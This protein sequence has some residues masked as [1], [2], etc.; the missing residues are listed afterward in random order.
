MQTRY[1]LAIFAGALG[2]LHVDA[3]AAA[4]EDRARTFELSSTIVQEENIDFGQ[5]GPT[6]GDAYAYS[7]NLTSPDGK[8]VGT[9]GAF[10]TDVRID[11]AARTITVNCN[12]TADLGDGQIAAQGLATITFGELAGTFTIPITGGS[13]AYS[14]V[15]GQLTV[16]K[17]DARHSRMIFQIARG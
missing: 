8:P 1:L 5:P 4:R 2:G 15:G 12:L 9:A 10:C 14:N 13:G 11:D 7:E 3:S 16:R 17:R 6:P